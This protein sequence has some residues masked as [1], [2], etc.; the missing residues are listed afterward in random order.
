MA[1]G[2]NQPKSKRAVRRAKIKEEQ[3]SIGASDVAKG[4]TRV[5]NGV[6]QWWDLDEKEWRLAAPLD[7]Y[8]HQI[9]AEDNAYD[10]YLF[11]PDSGVHE[12]D[13]T[14]FPPGDDY[15]GQ[16]YWNLKDKD[17]WG[18]IR[19]EEGN[20]VMYWVDR[21]ERDIETPDTEFMMYGNVIMLDPDDHP[22][23]DWPAI[24]R[25]FSSNLEAA[26]IEAL[27]RIHPWLSFP[28]FRARMPRTIYWKSGRP[29][30]LFGLSSFS[31][32][33]ARW[34]EKESC[35]PLRKHGRGTNLKEHIVARLAAQGLDQRSTEGL[36]PIPRK[37]VARLKKLQKGKF[38]ENV[39]FYT[40]TEEE[41]AQVSARYAKHSR[42]DIPDESQDDENASW[43]Y[44]TPPTYA[45][46]KRRREESMEPDLDGSQP[47]TKGNRSHPISRPAPQ[48]SSSVNVTP[49]P[50]TG[51]K[52]RRE[53]SMEPDLED[54]QPVTKP[55]RPNAM[56]PPT[57]QLPPLPAS[58]QLFS[59]APTTPAFNAQETVDG[60]YSSPTGQQYVSSIDSTPA[61][62]ANEIDFGDFVNVN[63]VSSGM[64]PDLRDIAPQTANERGAITFALSWTVA[65][66]RS[67]NQQEPPPT[68]P[69]E[70]YNAQY[71]RLQDDH[72]ERWFAGEE[73]EVELPPLVG[74]DVWFTSFLTV[75][76]PNVSD[77]VMQRL[78]E[79]RE[80][81]SESSGR[82][83]QSWGS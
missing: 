46:S 31:Q 58:S 54:Q 49:S 81:V 2:D 62:E 55:F 1:V 6:K 57:P 10:A 41:Q 73:S 29:K 14:T 67:M 33:L 61:G 38:P 77:E 45:G 83:S 7:D 56:S 80:K 22:I 5:E 78:Q 17:S 39:G 69:N 28:H 50:F 23:I 24:P 53:E 66:Y 76:M 8:R 35:V 47:T 75:P 42:E 64:G 43:V 30:D 20:K 63:D 16:K 71:Q 26:R 9:I 72:S 51:N 68:D 4:V 32:R 79:S 82:T 52:R 11:T 44:E 21:Q 70:S 15:L 74:I 60:T 37:E 65:D 18:N 25:C 59:Y 12:D 34:R 27:R 13:I 36:K 3:G 40:L 48:P 19:D